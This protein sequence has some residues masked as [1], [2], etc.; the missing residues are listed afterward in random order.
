MDKLEPPQTFSFD[1]NL[2]H[3]RK[4]WLKHLIFICLKWKKIQW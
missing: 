4:L 2:S 1:G 3:S